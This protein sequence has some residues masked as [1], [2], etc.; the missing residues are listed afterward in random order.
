MFLGFY[1]DF[2]WFLLGVS[3]FLLGLCLVLVGSLLGEKLV[4]CLVLV[5]LVVGFPLVTHQ[6]ECK[7]GM[8]NW[9]Y[10]LFVALGFS[11]L[12]THFFSGGRGVW[13]EQ[14]AS[15]GSICLSGCV[16]TWAS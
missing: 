4:V 1:L 10:I 2:T 7:K 5:G 14:Q 13:H 16:A 3:W 6:R 15:S 12:P 8:C 9:K 11:W